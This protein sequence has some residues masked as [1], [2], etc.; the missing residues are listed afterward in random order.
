MEKRL[1]ERLNKIKREKDNE[2]RLKRLKEVCSDG[3]IL[4]DALEIAKHESTLNLSGGILITALSAVLLNFIGDA[5]VKIVFLLL[6]FAVF[7]F[8]VKFEFGGWTDLYYDLIE[9][10]RIKREESDISKLDIIISIFRFL[11]NRKH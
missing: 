7:L 4:N 9:L 2:T 6:Y 10:R 1:F 11:C 8:L 3:D 5:T